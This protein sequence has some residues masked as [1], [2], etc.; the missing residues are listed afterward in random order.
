[1]VAKGG[2]Y[3]ALAVAFLGLA[4]MLLRLARVFSTTEQSIKEI[5]HEVVPLVG[6]THVT[7]DN[8]NS[9][10]T[11]LDTAVGDVS[12]IT[13][14][15]DQTTTVLTRGL[16]NGVIGLSAATAGI[17][18]GF[19]AFFGGESEERNASSEVSPDFE[20]GASSHSDETPGSR[21]RE[22]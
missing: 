14:E 21:E 1:M 8:V 20:P 5:S 18:R 16:R 13:G 22:G 6:K 17:S 19:G 2:L 15:L 9:Q 7:M 10:L 3:V 11:Q 4:W 12:G